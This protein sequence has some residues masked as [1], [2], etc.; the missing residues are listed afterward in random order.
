MVLYV[1]TAGGPCFDKLTMGG[2]DFENI[3]L[4][5]AL[6]HRTKD[7]RLLIFQLLPVFEGERLMVTKNQVALVLKAVP[8]VLVPLPC[9]DFLYQR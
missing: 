6:G 2:V 7:L 4:D 9:T 1:T 3:C 5:R 8:S